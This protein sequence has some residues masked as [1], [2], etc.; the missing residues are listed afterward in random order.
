MKKLIIILALCALLP[1]FVFAEYLTDLIPETGVKCLYYEGNSAGNGTTT[2]YFPELISTA[3]IGSDPNYIGYWLAVIHDVAGAGGAPQ[4][5]YREITNYSATSGV[6]TVTTAFTA[7]GAGDKVYLFQSAELHALAG[8]Q[9]VPAVTATKLAAGVNL[10]EGL[11]YVNN[12]VD[13]I[14]AVKAEY[15]EQML[16][17]IV[18]NPLTSAYFVTV[19]TGAQS[20]DSTWS[21]VATHEV[22]DVTGN[23]EFW[24]M[25]YDSVSYN[26]ADSL[27]IQV[28]G[29]EFTSMAKVDWDAGEFV[30]YKSTD[31]GVKYA[32]DPTLAS[33]G[34]AEPSALNAVLIHGYSFGLDIGY[35]VQTASVI[36]GISRW[37]LWYK[38]LSSNGT[39]VAG[40][41]G[42]L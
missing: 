5:E 23:I 34:C 6:L 25:V 17:N 12:T 24:L 19:T 28:G 38:P 41:G 32:I 27:I 22:F 15:A 33:V 2:L 29:V 26:G 3:K 4:A 11:L 18:G 40:A 16:E 1:S 20:V 36:A 37:L 8:T 7:L 13:T 14:N 10:A 35:E 9:G 39:V 30:Q 31:W 42:T 21:S